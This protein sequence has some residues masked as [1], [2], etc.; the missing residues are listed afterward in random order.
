M[1]GFS[2]ALAQEMAPL[3]VKV[4]I[5]EPGPFRTDFLGRSGVVAGRIIPDYEETVG[6]AREYFYGQ[7]G[8]Q[9]GDPRKVVQAMMDVVESEHPP[10]HLIL[11]AMAYQRFQGKLERL[12]EE[13]AKYERV[14]LD[15]DFPEGE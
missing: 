4:T 11:G 9:R 10:L 12:R 13:M 14:T 3:G 6:K 1:E 5:L 7:S 2:E 8:K 15:A